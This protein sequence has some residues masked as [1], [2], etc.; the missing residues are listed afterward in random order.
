[1]KTKIFYL[2]PSSFIIN[3]DNISTKNISRV[4][5]VLFMAAVIVL[6]SAGCSRRTYSVPLSEDEIVSVG[7]NVHLDGQPVGKVEKIERIGGKRCAT[8]VVSERSGKVA[9]REG[10]ERVQRN[11]MELSSAS[12]ASDAQPLAAGAEIKTRATVTNIAKGSL[13]AI[14]DGVYRAC[15]LHPWWVAVG[16]VVAVLLILSI[17]RR[18]LFLI[19]IFCGA[20]ATVS[21]IASQTG[22]SYS[23]QVLNGEQKAWQQSLLEV[24]C[25]LDESDRYLDAGLPSA[26]DHIVKAMFLIDRVD[27]QM[28][29]DLNHIS[30]LKTSLGY[31]RTEEQRRLN[32]GYDALRHELQTA[33]GR[34]TKLGQRCERSAESI[35]PIFL[36]KEE[37]YR[38]LARAGLTDVTVVLD[39]CHRELA[40]S[41][42]AKLAQIKTS[43]KD[44]T[45]AKPVL[46]AQSTNQPV[47]KTIF[48]TN[49]VR[50]IERFLQAPA[51][52]PQVTHISVPVVSNPLLK[53]N[54]AQVASPPSNPPVV[55]R[56]GDIGS[57]TIAT[58]PNRS[59]PPTTSNTTAN[60]KLSQHPTHLS[61]KALIAEGT[62]LVFGIG[63]LAWLTCFSFVRGRPH[64]LSLEF[65]TGEKQEIE[66]AAI[67]DAICLQTPLTR[68]HASLVNGTPNI[69]VGFRGPI[70]R[71]GKQT[72]RVNDTTVAKSQRLFP[73]DRIVVEGDDDKPKG[74]LFLGCDAV[75]AAESIEV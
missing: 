27:I 20:M 42:Q 50:I 5:L 3:W 74:F 52:T 22:I 55:D 73:G 38:H 48:L 59:G 40:K 13:Q 21:A 14:Q 28:E 18:A 24:E 36:L 68:E 49:E 56:V 25:D 43:I 53:T 46:P 65:D 63:V 31:I 30:M 19:V 26:P 1:M 62:G 61:K 60:Q 32:A 34:A 2:E 64:T 47:P 54:C 4:V 7:S 11:S 39:D 17:T 71:P 33:E 15:A 75:G 12:C 23:R 67:E 45:D 10:V 72:V 70:V 8:F 9:L 57:S 69:R 16:A 58:P 44:G 35:V 37:E 6:L 66:I 29:G 41:Q 51:P